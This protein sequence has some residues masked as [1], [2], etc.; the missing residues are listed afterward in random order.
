M[1]ELQTISPFGLNERV[2]GVGDVSRININV[3]SLFTGHSRRKRSHGR[4]KNSHLYDDWTL[5]SLMDVY[6]EDDPNCMHKLRTATYSLPNNIAGKIYVSAMYF[7][8]HPHV[9]YPKRALQIIRDIINRKLYPSLLHDEAS[10]NKRKQFLTLLFHNKGID[11]IN[12]PNI[13]HNKLV[14][15]SIPVYFSFREPPCIGY[16]Y[17][18]TIS[19]HIFN[20]KQTCRDF[21]TNNNINDVPCICSTI[22]SKFFNTNL[23]HV[24]SGNLEIVENLELRNLFHKGP[25]FRLQNHINWKKNRKIISEA[26]DNYIRKWAKK[27]NADESCLKD[28]KD[29]V[30]S[31]V[32]RK[33]VKLKR[34]STHKPQLLKRPHIKQELE[35][36]KTYYVLAPADK[37]VNNIIFICKRWYLQQMCTE[38][39]IAGNQNQPSAYNREITHTSVDIIQKHSMFNESYKIPIMVKEPAL[40]TI[41]GLPKM[42]KSPPKLRYIAA[43][44]SSSI[45]GLDK[46][47][48]KCLTAVYQF[49][50]TYCKTIY[51]YSGYNRMWIL[52]NSVQLKEHLSCI[53]EQSRALCVSTWDFSTL[54]TTIPHDKLKGRLK[55][56]IQ[57]VFKASKRDFFCA[58]IQKAFL[59]STK[60][61][62]YMYIDP[63]LFLRFLDYLIDNIYVEFGK[64][65]HKQTIGIPMGMCCAPLLANLF[66]MSYEYQF[67]KSLEKEEKFHAKQFNFTFRYID[68]LISLNNTT[69]DKYLQKIYPQELS[70]TKETQSD[71]AASYLDLFITISDNKF[72]TKLYDKR[73]SFGFT[74]I[75]YPH[76]V[77]SNIPEKPAYGVYA[78]RIISFARA[79][80]HYNDFS[81]RHILLCESLLKQGYKYGFLCKQLCSTFKKQSAIFAKYSKSFEDIKRDIPFTAMGVNPQF[82]TVRSQS[83]K[84]SS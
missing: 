63:I 56:L 71:K 43:S 50:K 39:N 12:I 44:C 42:H 25:K 67:M 22:D 31:L 75:N 59:S 55:E 79:C 53:N 32:D 15:E 41:Y 7:C 10:Q 4:R 9:K 73:D 38:L 83:R 47:M 34:I 49:M 8:Y 52:E 13:L 17:T 45:K 48:T 57:F 20:H 78:S 14:L 30:M 58:S 62:G 69:F 1:K 60:Y 65:L 61:K 70:I 24:V 11:L 28:Y 84:S 51:R 40:P 16:K 21:D 26:L 29:K 6:N 76:P 54:Y 3:E 36:L 23:G 2:D 19:K 5:D 64:T 72:H 82:V 37:A 77:T 18:S 35:R 74:I 66:L 33:I 27:E 81:E 46:L 68:D 80:D